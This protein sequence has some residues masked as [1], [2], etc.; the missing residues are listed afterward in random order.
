MR[1]EALLFASARG[2][3]VVGLA[4]VAIF[5]VSGCG[6]SSTR[7]VVSHNPAPNGIV[8]AGQQPVSGSTIQLYAAG[9]SGYGSAATALLASS[10]TSDANG[11]FSITGNY[12]CPSASTPV[13]LVATGGNPGLADGT[14]NAALALMAALGACGKLS[15]STFVNID[16]VTTVA[17][18][19]SLTQFLSVG[20]GAK[21]GTSS[22]NV[23]GLANAFAMVNN[24]VD[25]KTGIAPG[26]NLPSGSIA[27]TT[28]LNTLADIL[29]P[30]A[31]SNGTTGECSN[32]FGA[33]TSQGN[34]APTNTID[35]A[36]E[37]ALHPGN[38]VKT[39]YNLVMGAPPFQ[40]TLTS[41]PTDWTAALSY[42]GGGMGNLAFTVDVALDGSG[43]V[44]VLDGSCPGCGAISEFSSTGAAISS[45]A[46]YTG[47]GLNSPVHIAIDGSGSVWAV[48]NGPNFPGIS[49]FS[50]SEFS[51]SG[52][53]ISPAA[54]YTGGGLNAPEGIAVDSSGNIWVA[55]NGDNSLSEFSSAGVPISPA[56]GYTGGGLNSPFGVIAFDR[57]GNA[58]LANSGGNSLSEFSS[59]GTAISPSTGYTGG[60][61]NAPVGI[62]IDGSSNVWTMNNGP[63]FPGLVNS[64]SEF[65]STGSAISP[66]TGYTGGGL[67]QLSGLAIDGVNN[68]W[69]CNLLGNS[70]SEFSSTGIPISPASGYTG[71]GLDSPS[72]IAIDGSGNIWLTNQHSLTEFVGAAAPVVTPLATAAKNNLLGT[73][74]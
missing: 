61:L 12:T 10:V 21:L 72:S 33:A 7:Q 9:T 37:I 32:L 23:Q 57:S 63:N 13:Y 16:E 42:T 71:G 22:T 14:N 65:S 8:H 46:G 45:S 4:A 31:E 35:V 56:N 20:A 19:W 34:V 64:L 11:N 5:S 74:P 66:S 44:W 27:P 55:N 38:N 49:A 41:A 62:V 25:F 1:P 51:S 67:N 2:K 47:G 60:G 52:T 39:L 17:S 53:A 30:C 6:G 26:P 40:P 59:E 54:G 48:N 3:L 28:E 18:V 24:L 50:L 68:V 36:L 69:V 15:S 73:R 70:L 29:S 43:N 58:W